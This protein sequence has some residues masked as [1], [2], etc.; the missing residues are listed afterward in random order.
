MK[1]FQSLAKLSLALL[2]GLTITMQANASS[3]AV[4][5]DQVNVD[6]GFPAGTNY[7]QVTI[8]D[9]ADG[10]IDFKVETSESLSNQA[11]PN[12]G[13]QSFSLNFGDS[14][15]TAGN[16]QLNNGWGVKDNSPNHSIFGRFDVQINGTG[17]SRQDPLE[18]SIVGVAGDTPE[19][20]IKEF[21]SRN[22]LFA[23]HVAGFDSSIDSLNVTNS[24]LSSAQFGGSSVVPLPPAAWL[25]I[26][27][28]AVLGW[29]G[30]QSTARKARLEAPANATF[31]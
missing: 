15:A 29:R 10:N 30:K 20:Y 13:I 14:G 2:A 17:S 5:L 19:D 12:F 26:S 7:L 16:L 25:M 4:Y 31:A 6:L 3:L 11:G 23:A 8:S 9:G 18:F 1:T 27:G 22:T 24:N 21:S 28:L